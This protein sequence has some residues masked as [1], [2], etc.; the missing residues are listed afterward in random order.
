[1][2]HET[3]SAERRKVL[4]KPGRLVTLYGTVVSSSRNLGLS[5]AH[6]GKPFAVIYTLPLSELR[7]QARAPNMEVSPFA[8]WEGREGSLVPVIL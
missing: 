5:D 4:D 3:S 8:V 6:F 2:G 7:E 1:M